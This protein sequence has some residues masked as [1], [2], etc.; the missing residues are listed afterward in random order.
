MTNR[1]GSVDASIDHLGWGRTRLILVRDLRDAVGQG[2]VLLTAGFGCFAILS[3]MTP[4]GS[5]VF[6]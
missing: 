4:G 6:A 2:F 1:H 3:G 5:D